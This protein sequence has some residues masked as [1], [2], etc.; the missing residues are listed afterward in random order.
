MPQELD[1]II[2]PCLE[3][4]AMRLTTTSLTHSLS[5]LSSVLKMMD[6]TP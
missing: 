4:F 2:L 6:T 3:A 5:R 1:K